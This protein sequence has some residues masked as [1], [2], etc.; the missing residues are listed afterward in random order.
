MNIVT[1]VIREFG[2]SVRERA[3][4]PMG[5]GTSNVRRL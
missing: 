3:D 1:P 2:R 5:D 4:N